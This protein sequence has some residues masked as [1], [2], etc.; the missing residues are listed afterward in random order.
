VDRG[1]LKEAGIEAP[2]ADRMAAY[3]LADDGF[4]RF[5][6]EDIP[7]ADRDYVQVVMGAVR[8]A[9]R[10]RREYERAKAHVGARARP[11][12]LGSLRWSR[13]TCR[14]TGFGRWRRRRTSWVSPWARCTTGVAEGRA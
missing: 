6:W 3:V 5:V 13:W 4:P 9:Q 14:G 7:V 8:E 2:D 11:Q 1:V 12:T 10:W